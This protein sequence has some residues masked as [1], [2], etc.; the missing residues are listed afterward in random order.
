MK[1][2]LKKAREHPE[3]LPKEADRDF[4]APPDQEILDEGLRAVLPELFLEAGRNGPA[5][6]VEDYAVWARPSDLQLA[7]VSTPLHLWHGEEDRTI[8][9]AHSRWVAAQIP[10][11]ELTVWPGAGHLHTPERWAEVYATL[12]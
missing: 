3:R 12:N 2:S 6:I 8:P 10:S 1:R 5:G 11:A 9:V 7:G 4:Q